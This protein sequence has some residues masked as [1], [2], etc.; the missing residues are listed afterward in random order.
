MSVPRGG[1]RGVGG[2]GVAGLLFKKWK[3]KQFT[4]Y[5]RSSDPW[6]TSGKKYNV[7][8]DTRR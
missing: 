3:E 7:V 5:Q 4:A 6:V 8:V 1:Q 2:E